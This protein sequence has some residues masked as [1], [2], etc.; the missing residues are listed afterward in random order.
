MPVLKNLRHEQFAREYVATGIGAEAY[1]RAYPKAHPVTTARVNASR[2]LTIA[3]IA[4]RTAELR[5]VLARRADITEEKVLTDYQEALD[6]AKQQQ[7]PREIVSAATAQAKLV[8]LLVDRKEVEQAVDFDRIANINGILEAV[9]RDA[10][11]DAAAA[12]A[13]AFGI[14]WKPEPT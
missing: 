13:K 14:E 2:L 9:R 5:Q 10:G 11:E 4:N 8:G 3:N 12:L 7:R 6:L 1:R